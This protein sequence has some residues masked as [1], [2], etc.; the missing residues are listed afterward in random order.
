MSAAR[1]N[2]AAK[3]LSERLK[4]AGKSGKVILC[5]VMRKL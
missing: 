2:P 1:S 4:A 3:A 5:A